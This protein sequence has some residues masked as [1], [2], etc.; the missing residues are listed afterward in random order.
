MPGFEIF[1]DEERK[2]VMDVLE[3]G[4]LFRYNFDN[5]RNGHWK[6]L[7]F[8]KDLC[9]KLNVGYCHLCSSGTAALNIALASCGIGAG[10]EVIIPPFTFLATIESVLMA[11]AIPVF[12]EIDET[13]CLD[14]AD[15]EKK[16]TDKTRAVLVVHMCGSMAHIDA[17]DQVCKKKNILLIEDACQSLGST[18][19]GKALGSFGSSGCFSF[20]YVKTITCGEGG[21][22]ITNDEK[23]YTTAQAF[24]DHGHDHLGADR[25]QD[26]HPILGY[27]FRISELNA[28]VGVA[29]LRKLDQ[30]LDKQRQSKQIYK[31]ILSTCSAVSFRE[32]PDAEGDSATFLSILL[33]DENKTRQALKLFN[34]S[35]VPGAIYWYD[36]NWHYIRQ[37]DHLKDLKW[38]ARLTVSAL[39]D[40]FNFQNLSLP[41]SDAIMS[42]TLSFQIKLSDTE[43]DVEKHANQLKKI[44][45]QL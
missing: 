16:I 39:N 37:W 38:P 5:N 22:V 1:S 30:I 21:A 35:N 13:L 27:N 11:G 34:E 29:Q 45:D 23:V 19:K 15:I 32:I 40:S 18:F 43:A 31:K 25:G 28:A 41:A 7:S 2:E 42:R 4:V 17:I 26:K 36:N 8:E 44:L 12:A 33:P 14:P 6:A 20:D 9:K 24:A 10:D 3:T